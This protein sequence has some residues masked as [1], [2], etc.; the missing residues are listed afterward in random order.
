M[1]RKSRPIC[2]LIVRG[3]NR[4]LPIVANTCEFSTCYWVGDKQ[5]RSTGL[6]N[7]R[8]WQEA[9]KL[10]IHRP[11]WK[12]DAHIEECVEIIHTKGNS[13]IPV[14]TLAEDRRTSGDRITPLL[15][16]VAQHLD[17]L[18]RFCSCCA[19]SPRQRTLPLESAG[20]APSVSGGTDKLQ[21]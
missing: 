8:A 17:I 1:T 14:A 3:K 16:P 13:K 2:D 7:A 5:Q 6:T 18:P 10:Y 11:A 4:H 21:R 15:H 12:K 9:S 20:A 19:R